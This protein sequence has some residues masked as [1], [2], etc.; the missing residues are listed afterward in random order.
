MAGINWQVA[1]ATASALTF[2]AA[3][4]GVNVSHAWTRSASAIEAAIWCPVAAATSV[5][6]AVS[7]GALS[8]SR[9]RA[10]GQTVGLALAVLVTGS[11]SLAAALG[12]AHG[13]RAG[14]SAVE[15]S[16]ATERA[17]LEAER[18]RATAE[19]ATLAP[20]RGA[21]ELNP[22]LARLLATPAAN[23]CVRIDGP[24]SARVCAEVA[25]LQE[26]VAR[27]TRRA[28]LEGQLTRIDSDLSK[29]EVPARSANADA[30]ALAAYLR[31][32]GWSVE[33][34]QVN[35]WLALLTVALLETGAGLCLGVARALRAESEPVTHAPGRESLTPAPTP[36]QAGPKPVVAAES[37]LTHGSE[38]R[39]QT[40]PVNALSERTTLVLERLRDSGGLAVG[41]QRALADQFGVS[42][43]TVGRALRELYENG[44]VELSASKS[45]GTHVR[46][47]GTPN[48]SHG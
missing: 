22:H 35:R 40:V 8:G 44:L 15:S 34:D 31:A 45:T 7:I 19:L 10:L 3:S 20:A 21:M 9:R 32:F 43:S 29:V 16:R 12:A 6:F 1:G 18:N 27:A 37:A 4:V 26:E 30:H 25:G 42:Q 23:G 38:S 2:G 47:V 46:L 41:S 28:A 17:R 5:A 11:Y 36:V 13:M 48:V 24:V 39:A 14:A 33:A